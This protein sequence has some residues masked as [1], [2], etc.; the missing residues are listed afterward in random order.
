MTITSL[1]STSRAA[2]APSGETLER[3][4]PGTSRVVAA[5]LGGRLS[6][7]IAPESCFVVVRDIALGEDFPE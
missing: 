2:M 3:V 6:G 4:R 5:R 7:G 1:A